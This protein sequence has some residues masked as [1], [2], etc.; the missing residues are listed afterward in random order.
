MKLE[1]S[2]RI[3]E[4]SWNIQFNEN[5]SSGSRVI[6][7]GQTERHDK[8]NSRVISDFCVEV[9][10]AVLLCVITTTRCVITQKSQ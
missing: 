2:G 8:F 3:F 4:K 6:L 5:P 9:D 10:E 1:F 7:C